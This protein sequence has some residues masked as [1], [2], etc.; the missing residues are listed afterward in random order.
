MISALEKKAKA[1]N[2]YMHAHLPQIHN[3]RDK[4]SKK[5]HLEEV[6]HVASADNVADICNRREM[7]LKTLGPGSLW[8]S[9]PPWLST[10]YHIWP[11]NRDF[12]FK[13]LPTQETEASLC[14]IFAVKITDT[15]L[16]S[17]VQFAMQQL[18]SFSKDVSS[19]ARMG[20]L[21]SLT[22]FHILKQSA[23]MP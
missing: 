7:S 12:S 15:T 10:P 9:G 23:A 5:T 3:L 4:I 13:D 14:V 6:F 18:W 22:V 2:L 17:M 1:F 21:Q 16:P 11:Y 20:C 8:K 19:F